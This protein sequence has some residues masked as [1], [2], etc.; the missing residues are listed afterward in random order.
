M[1]EKEKA[2]KVNTKTNKQLYAKSLTSNNNGITLIALVVTIIV[3]LILAG[4]TI[5]LVLGEDGIISKAQQAGL[6]Q[7]L[8]EYKDKVEIA[9]ATVAMDKDN[10]GK[11]PIEKLVIELGN[12]GIT[13][14]DD[15]GDGIY[16]IEV[17]GIDE[18][19][20]LTDY[21]IPVP[22]TNKNKSFLSKI[23][24]ILIKI[25]CI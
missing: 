10:Y 6:A 23:I 18:T 24:S 22:N 17:P 5:N 2:T 9:K 14:E 11:V 4:V 12:Q 8:A 25:L 1:N 19:I 20:K 16:E 7:K 13:A 15:D 3:L 21:K